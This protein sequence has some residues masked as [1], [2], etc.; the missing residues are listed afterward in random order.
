[1]LTWFLAYR[2]GAGTR[3]PCADIFDAHVL[4][5]RGGIRVF[6]LCIGLPVQQK[7]TEGCLQ[8]ILGREDRLLAGRI[9]LRDRATCHYN[10]LSG[11]SISERR[12]RS[13]WRRLV[14]PG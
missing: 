4:S 7:L 3:S 5:C 9:C 12:R 11:L 10:R 6:A 14:G 13:A 2:Q 8:F 1:M